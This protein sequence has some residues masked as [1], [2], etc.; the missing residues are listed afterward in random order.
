MADNMKALKQL[1]KYNTSTAKVENNYSE[2]FMGNK[3]LQFRLDLS[4]T[5]LKCILIEEL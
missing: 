3:V 4:P 2:E 5:F 1:Y